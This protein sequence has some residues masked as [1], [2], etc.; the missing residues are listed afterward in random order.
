[1]NAVD[2]IGVHDHAAA[3]LSGKNFQG[4]LGALCGNIE[5][6]SYAKLLSDRTEAKQRRERANDYPQAKAVPRTRQ[7]EAGVGLQEGG[8]ALYPET[9]GLGG[10][11]KWI[12]QFSGCS[13]HSVGDR[14][15]T[16]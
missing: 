2:D 1:M 12:H 10:I 9:T 5:K 15:V 8:V 13:R 16:R 11:P 6:T 7:A 3:R 4:G 14:P